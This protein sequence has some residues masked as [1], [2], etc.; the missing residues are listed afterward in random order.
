MRRAGTRRRIGIVAR[1]SR[2][3]RRDAG[4]R[5]RAA[6]CSPVH[7]VPFQ[8]IDVHPFG[9][10]ADFVSPVAL[11]PRVAPG[12]LVRGFQIATQ[13]VQNRS[14]EAWPRSAVAPMAG[15]SRR[16]P[17]RIDMSVAVLLKTEPSAAS[18]GPFGP[19]AGNRRTACGSGQIPGSAARAGDHRSTTSQPRRVSSNRS[20]HAR[21]ARHG[22]DS[23]EAT[24]PRL[25]RACRA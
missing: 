23:M 7:C 12:L 24:V 18:G 9:D 13:G 25:A 19:P 4:R 8:N 2:R 14:H 21:M 5:E 22:L 10:P 15:W 16:S 3:R 1:T 6:V 20:R 17:S 11:R